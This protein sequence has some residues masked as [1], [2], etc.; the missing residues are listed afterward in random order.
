MAY[1]ALPEFARRRAARDLDIFGKRRDAGVS[2]DRLRL[3][4]EFRGDAVTLVE[5]RIPWQ[6]GMEGQPWTRTPIARFRYDV[7]AARWMLYWPDRDTQWHVDDGIEPAPNLAPQVD[8]DPSGI[9]WG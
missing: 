2:A 5:R 4:Y 7:K 3:E 9:Y 1:M 8:R 6:P